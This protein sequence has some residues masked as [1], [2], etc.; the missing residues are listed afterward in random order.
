M[1]SN[2]IIQGANITNVPY[3]AHITSTNP[4]QQTN[5]VGGGS[6]ISQRHVLTSAEVLFQFTQFVV[7]MGSILRSE[8]T[9]FA[10]F[11][12]TPHPS[13]DPQSLQINN[14][15]IITLLNNVVFSSTIQPISISNYAVRE[16][17]QG[18]I[19]GF[20]GVQNA[21]QLLA[22]FPRIVS[23]DRCLSRWPGSN[24]ASIFCAE[25][26]NLRS[27][28]CQENIGISLTILERG[29]ERI[30]GIA[31]QPNCNSVGLSQPSVYT[32]VFAIRA[33]IT[34]QTGV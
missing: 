8:Q 34:G 13:Y 20:G 7:A 2:A 5:R 14:I 10:V 21:Q 9:D 25:D 6:L 18:M 30:V 27:D 15:G 12:A 11:S 22:A 26:T 33:W 4:T 32:S 28:F 17:E 1:Q 31:I 19:V 29:V 23:G 24:L 3:A 16:N